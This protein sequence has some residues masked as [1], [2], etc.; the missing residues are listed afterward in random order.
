MNITD[1][2]MK[3]VSGNVGE[4]VRLSRAGRVMDDQQK[5]WRP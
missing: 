2:G 4:E 1:N 3:D 5:C